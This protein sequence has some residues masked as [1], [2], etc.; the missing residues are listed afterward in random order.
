MRKKTHGADTWK[1]QHHA[2]ICQAMYYQASTCMCHL[3][4]LKLNRLSRLSP[5]WHSEV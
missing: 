3:S 5:L 2:N 4:M 1:V